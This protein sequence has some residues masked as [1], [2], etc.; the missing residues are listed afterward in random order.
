ML[1][2]IAKSGTTWT[3]EGEIVIISMIGYLSGISQYEAH[4]RHAITKRSDA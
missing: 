2:N 1:Y 3:F 4:R